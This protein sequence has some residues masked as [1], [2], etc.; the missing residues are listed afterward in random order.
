MWEQHLD[1]LLNLIVQYKKSSDQEVL[2][3]ILF[4]IDEL[5][6]KSIHKECFRS[7]HLKKVPFEDLY[8][9]GVEYALKAISKIKETENPIKIPAWIT[10]YVRY[11]IVKEFREV[12]K[13]VLE[14]ELDVDGSS[15]LQLIEKVKRDKETVFEK[16][17]RIVKLL[18][19]DLIKDCRRKRLLSKGEFRSLMYFY[20]DDLSVEEIAKIEKKSIRLIYHRIDIGLLKLKAFLTGQEFKMPRRKKKY[21]EVISISV[22]VETYFFN[23]AEVELESSEFEIGSFQRSEMNFAKKESVK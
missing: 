23:P 6:C 14:S 18:I 11:G 10:H 19:F 3:Q 12:K 15:I 7:P 21:V 20:K 8:H 16:E 1:S 2:N 5:I 17:N 22:S 9:T 4:R 13:L